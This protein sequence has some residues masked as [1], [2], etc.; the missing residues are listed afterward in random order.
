MATRKVV[1]NRRYG[2][3][4][5]SNQAVN[6]YAAARGIDVSEVDKYDI[7]RDDAD[8]VYVVETLG[9]G[10]AGRYSQL[11]IVE[12]PADVEWEI[13]EY[14]GNEWVAEVHRTWS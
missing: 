14:D 8:L 6:M 7:A 13:A 12:I 4:S 11:K 9:E 5:L 1:I 10:A 2:G 3:F